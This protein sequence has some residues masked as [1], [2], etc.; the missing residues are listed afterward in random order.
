MSQ[1][2]YSPPS[3][4]LGREV[5]PA[6]DGRGVFYIRECLS[7]GWRNTWG[8]FPLWLG[9]GIVALLVAAT[10]AM[11]VIGAVVVIPVLAWGGVRF[12]LR[13]HDGDAAFRD[14]FSGFSRYVDALVG[15]IVCFVLLFLVAM[16]GAVPQLAGQLTGSM[17]LFFAGYAF[18]ILFTLL[19]S[20]RLLFAYFY[21][22]DRGLAPVEAITRSWQ[23]TDPVKW[24]VAGLLLTIY[25][26]NVVGALALLVGLIPASVISYL[27][28]CSAFRQMEGRPA[29]A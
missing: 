1:N 22:V 12:G 2:P 3:A 27:M 23:T 13:M 26:V 29:T 11:T 20:A 25:A 8:N 17:A 21:V 5:L 18:N 10:A 6:V 16:V 14:L 28:W 19:V 4:D 7:D 24:K 15:M 9:V